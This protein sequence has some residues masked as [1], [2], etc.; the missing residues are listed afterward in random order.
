[1]LRTV[2][3]SPYCTSDLVHVHCI[4]ES[5]MK[6]V[7]GKSAH[8]AVFIFIYHFIP[9]FISIVQYTVCSRVQKIATVLYNDLISPD[10]VFVS[11]GAKCDIMRV[12]QMFGSDVVSA[13][14]DPSYPV[15]V[16]TSVIMGHTGGINSATSQYDNIVCMPCNARISSSP[17]TAASLPRAVDVYF[18]S[19]NNPTGA[20]PPRRSLKV[21]SRRVLSVDPFSSLMRRILPS[22]VI[23][24]YQSLFSKLKVPRS[25][26]W[27]STL[28]PRMLDSHECVL[29]GLSFPLV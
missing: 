12:Q 27:R 6:E 7:E 25:A 24:M 9:I 18:C 10:E 21:W 2:A 4:T 17:I 20:A 26:P 15:Y 29:D 3:P 19:P 14:Q 13:V 5:A 11:D 16:D 28:S 1:M 22:S 8:N 23:P